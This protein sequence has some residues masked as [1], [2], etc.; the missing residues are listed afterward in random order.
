[1]NPDEL[2]LRL[3]GVFYV[4]FRAKSRHYYIFTNL[5]PVPSLNFGN[6]PNPTEDI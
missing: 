3:T 1:M 6:Y 4:T 5:L 2:A